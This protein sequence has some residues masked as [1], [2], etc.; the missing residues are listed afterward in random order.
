[1]LDQIGYFVSFVIQIND[2]N[3]GLFAKCPY[4]VLHVCQ[5]KKKNS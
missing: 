2:V 1:M 3:F 4:D 5:K